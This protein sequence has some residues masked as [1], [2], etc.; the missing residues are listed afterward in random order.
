MPP[1]TGR[2]LHASAEEGFSLVELIVAA[3]ILVTAV[4]GIFTA[5][6]AAG[7]AG[8][9]ERSR[10]VAYQLA[11]EDQ[12][13][14]RAMKATALLG[15]NQTGLSSTR[16]QTVD[17]TTY[18]VKSTTKITSD[19]TGTEAC[20]AGSASADY[21]SIASTVTWPTMDVKPVVIQSIVSPSSGSFDPD[22]GAL[23][24]SVINGQGVGVPNVPLRG[25]GAG[26]FNGMTGD[27]GCVV[28]ANLP[29]GTY[30][31]TPTATGLVDQ[32]G[33]AASAQPASVLSGATN[34]KV[35]QLDQPGA[36]DVTFQT[37]VPGQTNPVTSNADSIMVFNT[38]MTTAE[39]FGT[40]G[41]RVPKITASPLFPFSSPDTV[42]AG[43]CTGNL[44]PATSPLSALASATVN[45]G[46]PTTTARVTLPA[47]DV[48]VR[49]GS[50]GSNQGTLVNGAK[51]VLSDD[52]CSGQKRTLFTNSSGKLDDPGL[53]WSTYD[54]CV[55]GRTGSSS[56]RLM[57]F[58]N[59]DIKNPNT[60]TSL[61][62]YLS[63]FG[64]TSTTSTGC[65]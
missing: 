2:N 44:P 65:T 61:P 16:T 28:F 3:A 54:I 64:S 38:G 1:R 37:K 22:T 12:A 33:N 23:A 17:G 4:V 19:A 56:F 20:D 35:F 15:A 13:R 34:T 53:P 27:A 52:N 46:G 43:S 25:T 31:V 10:A 63:A 8:A 59:V 58:N 36:I 21:L 48:T 50:S 11:Q 26:S 47:F 14:M 60:P 40:V 24:I 55:S 45:P 7:R 39:Q 62:V 9:D 5:L 32:D 30:S 49:T 41:N 57:R 29:R 51:I 42:Y 18:T 6:E